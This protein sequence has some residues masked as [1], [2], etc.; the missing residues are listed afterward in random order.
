MLNSSVARPLCGTSQVYA[1]WMMVGLLVGGSRA[2]VV[3]VLVL[4]VMMLT[5]P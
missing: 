1:S 3:V 2:L 5:R 4:L